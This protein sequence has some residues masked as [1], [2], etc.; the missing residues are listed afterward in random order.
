MNITNQISNLDILG[1][2]FHVGVQ[3]IG[4][5]GYNIATYGVN[6]IAIP[7]I[8]YAGSVIINY[9]RC[10][11]AVITIILLKNLMRKE[12]DLVHRNVAHLGGA[13]GVLPGFVETGITFVQLTLTWGLAYYSVKPFEDYLLNRTA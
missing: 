6:D 7:T 8:E 13:A 3:A 10:T 4:E 2:A 9:P 11:T 12:K 1:H 5:F